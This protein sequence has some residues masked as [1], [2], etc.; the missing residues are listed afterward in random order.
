MA[1]TVN[2]YDRVLLL[3]SGIEFNY[4]PYYSLF[5]CYLRISWGKTP[6]NKIN[7][8]NKQTNKTKANK[9][10]TKKSTNKNNYNNKTALWNKGLF[11]L[12]GV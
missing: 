10:K 7:Q 2:L 12:T 11:C 9:T 8:S 1:S 5:C 3:P 6:T 4:C